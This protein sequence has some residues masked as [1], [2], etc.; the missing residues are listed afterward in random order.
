MCWLVFSSGR[1]QKKMFSFSP[2]ST[3]GSNLLQPLSPPHE[4]CLTII[5]KLKMH[6]HGWIRLGICC[7]SGFILSVSFFYT[8][9][10]CLG[11]RSRRFKTKKTKANVCDSSS[12]ASN[13]AIAG[14][15]ERA[16]FRVCWARDFSE[17]KA[18]RRIWGYGGSD[19]SELASKEEFLT[20]K[21]CWRG[22]FSLL[23]RH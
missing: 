19:D 17:S 23:N 9:N 8:R 12:R 5:L 22:V 1:P 7:K 16:A 3:I 6:L 10:S 13:A 14:G 11:F 2:R 4:K 20:T 15:K 21:Q 18:R